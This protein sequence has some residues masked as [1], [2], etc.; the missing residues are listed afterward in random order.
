MPMHYHGN[1]IDLEEANCN[2]I[3]H[4]KPLNLNDPKDAET[5][6][7]MLEK[8]DEED[9]EDEDFKLYL[10]DDEPLKDLFPDDHPPEEGRN[11][12]HERRQKNHKSHKLWKRLQRAI[13]LNIIKCRLEAKQQKIEMLSRIS[14]PEISHNKRMRPKE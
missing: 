3:N 14:Y 4:H 13:F 1:P 5:I 2:I 6:S 7:K 8:S 10:T 9:K 12:A 11:S